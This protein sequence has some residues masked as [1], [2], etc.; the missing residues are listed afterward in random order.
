[1][2]PKINPVS[3]P[4][5]ISRVSGKVAHQSRKD[6]THAGPKNRVDSSHSGSKAR[7]E[8][9]PPGTSSRS[10]SGDSPSNLPPPSDLSSLFILLKSTNYY[11]HSKS[12]INHRHFILPGARKISVPNQQPPQSS[13]PNPQSSQGTRSRRSDSLIRNAPKPIATE[14]PPFT[15][16]K[17]SVSSQPQQG[18]NPQPPETLDS[19]RDG[20]PYVHPDDSAN[21]KR[22]TR[23]MT[24]PEILRSQKVPNTAK[25]NPNSEPP[26]KRTELFVVPDHARHHKNP[27]GSYAQAAKPRPHAP[28]WTDKEIRL[29]ALASHLSLD[30]DLWK[31]YEQLIVK[32]FASFVASFKKTDPNV[33][34]VSLQRLYYD[35][36]NK[37]G[38]LEVGLEASAKTVRDLLIP[39][40][41]LPI[42]LKAVIK[43]DN[44]N[45]I[46]RCFLPLIFQAYSE[47]EYVDY[48]KWSN[49]IME[50]N[51]VEI[52]KIERKQN[53]RALHLKTTM[54]IAEYVRQHNFAIPH[55]LGTTFF[56][57][58]ILHEATTFVC[59]KEPTAVIL[60]QPIVPNQPNLVAE[61]PEISLLTKSVNE[62]SLLSPEVEEHFNMLENEN[63]HQFDME[64]AFPGNPHL[65]S[66]SLSQDLC[67]HATAIAY[68][69]LKFQA[70]QVSAVTMILISTWVPRPLA[71]PRTSAP[72]TFHLL[73][74]APKR[75]LCNK[76]DIFRNGG[77]Q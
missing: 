51:L 66:N 6:P 13:T 69:F 58:K 38:V 61:D 37:C 22:K 23:D 24:D 44:S 67:A 47:Q 73:G 59:T 77:N 21:R 12:T 72:R 36:G 64:T 20:P 28:K 74:S 57:P 68:H 31:S 55:I 3:I 50:S 7:V 32:G 26:A 53:G 39:T 45:P 49:P 9:R 2:A 41:N 40:L 70:I 14:H 71:H 15:I 25:A 60:N 42:Q 35:P 11:H 33:R 18:S 10:S 34:Q 17:A 16:P 5:S 30:R 8:S 1:M 52:V 62:A 29:M 19:P 75:I 63:P 65:Y 4:N 43:E 76:T 46:L 56:D 48:L 54:E 27:K